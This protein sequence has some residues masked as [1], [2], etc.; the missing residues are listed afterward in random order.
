[1]STL[2]ENMRYLRA[3]RNCSQQ[4]VADDL[5]I[6]RARYSKYEEGV[7]EPPLDILQRISRYFQVSIDLLLAVDMRRVPMAD[8]LKLEG[9]RI[10]L[11]IKVDIS[12]ENVIEVI[13][14][15]SQAGYLTGYSDPEYIES[16]QH[17]SL[18]FT[19][20]GKH[21]A[22]PVIGDSMPP[23]ENGTYIIGK[24]IEHLS[25]LKPENTCILMLRNE[26]MVYKRIVKVNE[27]SIMVE[28]DNPLFEPYEIK[29]SEVLEVWRF[30]CNIG[31][32]DRRPEKKADDVPAMFNEVKKEISQL[33]DLIKK[34][35]R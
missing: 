8:L 34:S 33:K 24:Y 11:P 4:K 23:H 21:R 29:S 27:D 9:N 6:T 1:M 5:V 19:G 22:F 25:E 10:L 28:S 35:N 12:G 26:G 13:P 15:K 7:S 3:Q 30:F 2:S 14:H 20:P 31:F 17:I 18:P 16:L 32:V